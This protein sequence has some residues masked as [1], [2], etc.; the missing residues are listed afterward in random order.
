VPLEDSRRAGLIKSSLQAAVVLP[1]PAE[2]IPLLTPEE[3]AELAIV[4]QLDLVPAGDVPGGAVQVAA[5]PGEKCA[6]CWRVLP[7]VGQAAGH[8]ALCLRCA[9]AVDSGLVCRP[10]A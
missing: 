7:E 10:A 4:S 2:D 6:R 1:L 3:W 8:A 9:D 5:A